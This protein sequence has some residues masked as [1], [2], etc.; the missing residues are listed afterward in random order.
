M[1]RRLQRWLAYSIVIVSVLRGLV[2]LARLGGVI[3]TVEAIG[4]A[5]GFENAVTQ[6][7]DGI[8]VIVIGSIELVTQ[9]WVTVFG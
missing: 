6:F 8:E 7:E 3:G 4:I 9:L 1:K 2:F 5:F